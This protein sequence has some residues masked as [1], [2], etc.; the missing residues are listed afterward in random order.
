MTHL[1]YPFKIFFK[2]FTLSVF[3]ALHKHGVIVSFLA[4]FTIN[5]LEFV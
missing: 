5:K 3:S 4:T 2:F 1:T